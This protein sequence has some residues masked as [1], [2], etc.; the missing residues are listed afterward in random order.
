MMPPGPRVPQRGNAFSRW[1]G[2]SV[3]RV[4]GWRVEGGVP[5]LPKFVLIGAPHTTNFDAV[6]A[7]AILM[8]LGLRASTMVKDS[9]FKGYTGVLLRWLGATPINRRSPK[10]VIEQ[11][12]DAFA[13]NERFVLLLAPEGTRAAA[14]AWKRGFHHVAS[15]AGVPVVA[16]AIDYQRKLVTFGAPVQP[17]GDY[18]ADLDR[19]QRFVAE[20]SWPRHAE[21]LSKP[22]A[23]LQGRSWSARDES[24]DD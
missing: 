13:S 21:R 16:A 20:H 2:R 19:L 5:D 24:E 15:G 14:P 9:A 18:A 3:L 12:V 11:T 23:E 4:L 17:S 1:F 10:G 7:F 8:G 22:I 6:I